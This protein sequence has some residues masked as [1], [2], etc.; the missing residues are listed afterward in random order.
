M[1]TLRV[2]IATLCISSVLS[3][4]SLS[5]YWQAVG[6]QLD[7]L[8][9]RMPIEEVLERAE[10]SP[11]TRESLRQVLE[12]RHFA[13]TELGLPDNGSY[14]SY[15]DLGRAYVVWNV[16]AAEEFSVEPISWCFPFAGCVS[17]RGYFDEQAARR[18]SAHLD[19]EGFDTTVGGTTAYSTLGYFAD[20]VLNT[21]IESGGLSIVALLIHELAH[22]RF[23]LQDDSELNEAFATAV[24]EYGT[25]LWLM[26]AGDQD[27]IAEYRARMRRRTD[28][29]KLV[30]DQQERLREVF[31][32]GDSE[33]SKRVAKQASFDVMRTEYEALRR[34]WGG[35]TDYDA[36]FDRPLNNAHLVSVATYRRWLPGLR[37][38]LEG[39]GLEG[40]YGQMEALEDLSL[41]ERRAR[42]EEWL[43]EAFNLQTADGTGRT[44]AGAEPDRLSTAGE[45]LPWTSR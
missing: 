23:Y 29:S 42:L 30:T 3:G 21:M 25:E 31:D 12:I 13:T 4:C 16:V 36:W 14:R 11:R 9:K 17:Y 41:S 34:T 8:R 10:T 27:A 18:F 2:L 6:G 28:F 22:Q 7:L 45:S 43:G 5:Y 15:V 40:F 24:E 1:R 26:R 39:Q 33:E 35:V 20:P 19:A 37:W 38:L 44:V 32:R